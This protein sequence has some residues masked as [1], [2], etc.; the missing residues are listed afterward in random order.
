MLSFISVLISCSLNFFIFLQE[1]HLLPPKDTQTA[2]PRSPPRPGP[3]GM[4]WPAHD[5]TAGS[6]I[7]AVTAMKVCCAVNT[8]NAES[9]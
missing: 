6:G 1:A 3:A 2:P 7:Q 4:G 5:M 9:Q 8:Q